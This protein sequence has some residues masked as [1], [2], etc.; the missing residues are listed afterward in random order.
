MLEEIKKRVLEA[1]LRL[2]K[3]NLVVLT[4]GNVSEID[5]DSGLV[6]IKPSGV[7]YDL[8]KTEDMVVCDLE[9]NV[10][11][12]DLRPSV[13]LMT[14][15]E[16]YKRF[17]KIRSVV[18]DH[19]TY[20]TSFAQAKREIIPFGTTH[21]DTFHSAIPCTEALTKEQIEGDYVRETAYAIIKRF[22][23]LDYL[24]DPGVLVAEH[25]VFTWG[26]GPDEAVDN[27]VVVEEVAKMAYLT[28][29]LKPDSRPIE[30][31]LLE[32]HYQRKHG[33][34]HSYGQEKK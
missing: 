29:A 12:G 19:S 33:K 32:K 11:E 1:N 27:A 26:T 16:L 7:S 9:G 18:H 31:Y 25:G 17:L 22:G 15:I 13:D 4:W 30:D 21:A 3:E 23:N 20:A 24:A 28:L 2:K 34:N 8:M 14:H 10:V 6:V 5:R